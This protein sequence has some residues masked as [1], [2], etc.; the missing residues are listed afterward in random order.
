MV[1][2]LKAKSLLQKVA[3]QKNTDYSANGNSDPSKRA[4]ISRLVGKIRC[5]WE[6]DREQDSAS[7][8]S[9]L[10]VLVLALAFQYNFL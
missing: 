1:E 10:L 6:Q 9:Y 2:D 4:K 7:G 8:R 3:F 5:C